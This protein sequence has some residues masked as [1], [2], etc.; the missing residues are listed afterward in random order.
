MS[1]LTALV[2]SKIVVG[3]VVAGVAVTGAGAAVAY[4]GSL[5]ASLQQVAHDTIDAPA[6]ADAAPASCRQARLPTRWSRRKKP[7]RIQPTRQRKRRH[8]MR[9]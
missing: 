6:P 4:T 5:P 3:V 9:Q 8:Q 1:V 7:R 2:A